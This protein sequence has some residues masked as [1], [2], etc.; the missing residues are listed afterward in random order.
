M[1][2]HLRRARV[3]RGWSQARLVHEIE[4][5]SRQRLVTV[6]STNSLGVYVSDWENGRR[7]I[8]SSYAAILRRL[9]GTTD[10]EL[11]SD[12]TIVNDDRGGYAQLVEHLDASDAVD[13]STLRALRRQ[14]EL[15]RTMDRQ[16][17]AA[18]LV[19]QMQSHLV[20]L[21]ENLSFAVLPSAR[22]PLAR[23]LAEAAS[24]AAWQ[25]LDVGAADRA[26]RHYEMAKSAAREADDPLHLAHATG[27]QAYV[28]ADAGRPE[29]GAQL[30]QEA[31]RAGG[32]RLSPRLSA[33]LA[34]AEAELWALSQRSDECQRSLDRASGLLSRLTGVRDPDL[35]GIFLDETHLRRWRGH[36]LALL[37]DHRSIDELSTALTAMDDTFVRAAAGIRCDLA[38]AHLVR[39]ETREARFHLREASSLV[40]LTGS[41]RYRLRV[42]R[43]KGLSDAGKC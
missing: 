20:R 27:E 22:Q 25:A 32:K 6:A 33:W 24:L 19:D 40:N 43:I 16:L 29:L 3:A 39:G 18:Q 15:L 7:K 5:Y 35:P 42:D 38:Q 2:N 23:A 14:T 9:L 28:L 36:S 34:A 31:Q 11:F 21:Q 30:V 1:A 4:Q 37:G 26:W 12:V 13:Q 10:D 8:S 17:G 41:V